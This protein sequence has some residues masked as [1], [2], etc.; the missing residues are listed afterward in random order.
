MP[1][2]HASKPPAGERAAIGD[3]P[4]DARLV[5]DFD[6]EDAVLES[7]AGSGSLLFRFN[8]GAVLEWTDFRARYSEDSPPPDVV[9]DGQ[10]VSGAD[11]LLAL[12]ADP[13]PGAHAE[14]GSPS[15]RR[16]RG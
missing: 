16:E 11:F 2:I 13:V 10:P 6:P 8:D 15:A 9:I 5:L 3:I 14:G 7:P 4:A 1:D 12:G